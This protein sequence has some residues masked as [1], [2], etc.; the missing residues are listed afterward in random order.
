MSSSIAQAGPTTQ[1]A[2]DAITAVAF[3]PS[4]ASPTIVRIGCN[5][6][7]HVLVSRAGTVA[8]QTNA[9]LVMS[10]CEYVRV[11]VGETVSVI[12]AT[13]ETA[14]VLTFTDQNMG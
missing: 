12:A 10:G 13:G 3:D 1:S 11:N 14:G 8:T 6:A 5:R 4:N 2:I 9:M 7:F